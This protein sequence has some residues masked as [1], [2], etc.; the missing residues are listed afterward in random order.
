MAPMVVR[1]FNRAQ[2]IVSLI[3]RTDR[4]MHGELWIPYQGNRNDERMSCIRYNAFHTP[5]FVVL[6]INHHN[7]LRVETDVMIST[8]AILWYLGDENLVPN[9]WVDISSG[10]QHRIL[11][12][13]GGGDGPSLWRQR[14]PVYDSSGSD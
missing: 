10:G 7:E 5:T 14:D 6:H 13:P 9:N 3:T 2:W 4:C 11:W 12:R 8:N 1:V